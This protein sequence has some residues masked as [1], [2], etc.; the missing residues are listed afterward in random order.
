MENNKPTP[1]EFLEVLRDSFEGSTIIYTEGSCG[2][3][4]K[5]LK[6]V[7]PEAQAYYDG[8]H[9]LTKIGD[10]WY[11]ILGEYTIA[12]K[13]MPVNTKEL[14]QSKADIYNLEIDCDKLLICRRE[15]LR[16]ISAS[17]NE[18]AEKVNQSDK[19]V[20]KELLSDVALS[21]PLNNAF[22]ELYGVDVNAA[23]FIRYSKRRLAND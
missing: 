23:T 15:V 20:L 16:L 12:P 17:I 19:L 2:E 3:L 21:Q 22:I 4:H 11:D 5:I 8:D 9:T 13:Y 6:C 7:Y 10:R 14:I 1:S 18:L